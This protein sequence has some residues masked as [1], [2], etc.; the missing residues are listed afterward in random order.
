MPSVKGLQTVNN[1]HIIDGLGNPADAPGIPAPQGSQFN[2]EDLGE[3][4]IKTGPGDQDWERFEK[5]EDEKELRAVE[6][7]QVTVDAYDGGGE[8]EIARI[9]NIDTD[10]IVQINAYAEALQ[11][12][13]P[14]EGSVDD[15]FFTRKTY[16]V[17]SGPGAAMSQ[18]Q[19]QDDFTHF[20]D[21]GGNDNEM[22]VSL[23]LSVAG[24][25]GILVS[26]GVDIGGNTSGREMDWHCRLEIVELRSFA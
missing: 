22:S 21:A 24:E 20:E 23:D 8:V 19:D 17:K 10:R 15:A 16:A 18:L 1:V 26:N 13:A 25:V 9:T 14:G 4:Y 6:G 3:F 7:N 11:T 5:A 12:G 2:S